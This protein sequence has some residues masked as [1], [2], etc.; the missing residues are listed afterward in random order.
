MGTSGGISVKVDT[1]LKVPLLKTLFMTWKIVSKDEVFW[2]AVV[3][4]RLLSLKYRGVKKEDFKKMSESFGKASKKEIAGQ[5]F[6][7]FLKVA[8]D[9]LF[10]GI[11]ATGIVD[12]FL[13]LEFKTFVNLLFVFTFSFA[14]LDT[15]SF[16]KVEI[17]ANGYREEILEIVDKLYDD[18]RIIRLDEIIEEVR[19]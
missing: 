5:A 10:V 8:I 16:V 14:F 3:I 13:N 11:I 1:L 6:R 12:A 4:Q 19:R 17:T 2:K 15:L 18:D 9:D 7:Y